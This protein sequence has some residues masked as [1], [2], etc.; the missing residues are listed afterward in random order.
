MAGSNGGLSASNRVRVTV[1]AIL[2]AMWV[3][4]GVK[5]IVTGDITAFGLVTGPFTLMCGYVF[6]VSLL[7]RPE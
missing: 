6:G 5:A 1:T 4:A 7:R 3:A 2:T